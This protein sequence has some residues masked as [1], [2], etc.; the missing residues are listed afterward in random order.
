MFFFFFNFFLTTFSFIYG[1][2]SCSFIVNYKA[3]ENFYKKWKMKDET[4]NFEM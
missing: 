1:C 2:E 3:Q 4:N